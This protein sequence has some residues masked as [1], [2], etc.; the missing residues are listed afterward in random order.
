MN[1]LFFA[2]AEK[3]HIPIIMGNSGS[4]SYV[5]EIPGVEP[6]AKK[7]T[8]RMDKVRKS[9][10]NALNRKSNKEY[11]DKNKMKKEDQANNNGVSI[12]IQCF[13]FIHHTKSHTHRINIRKSITLKGR[14]RFCYEIDLGCE[15]ADFNYPCKLNAFLLYSL[16]QRSASHIFITSK[17]DLST[18]IE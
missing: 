14:L 13:D 1:S 12:S 9:I 10:R 17:L 18:H 6:T 3:A 16:L 15:L 5:Y 8:S 7:D 4:S 2:G 11:F